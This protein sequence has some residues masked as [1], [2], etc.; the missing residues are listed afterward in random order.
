MKKK[1]LLGAINITLL[2]LLAI[3]LLISYNY[4]GIFNKT[5]TIL[6]IIATLVITTIIIKTYLSRKNPIYNIGAYTCFNKNILI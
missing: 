6:F 4:I 2:I 3:I 5:Q 1:Y